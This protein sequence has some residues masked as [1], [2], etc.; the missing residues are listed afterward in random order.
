M[1]SRNKY[2]TLVVLNPRWSSATYL[3]S[4]SLDNKKDYT[5]LKGVLDEALEGYAKK[6]GPFEKKQQVLSNDGTHRFKHVTEFCCIKQKSGSVKEAFYALHHLKGFVWDAEKTKLP[7]SLQEWTK[8][9]GDITDAD[10]REDFHRIQVQLSRII[11]EDVNN[12]RGSLHNVRG[13]NKCFFILFIID[14]S[15]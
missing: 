7:S 10:L 9:A 3:D 12:H 11:I 1:L 2:C 4:G 8:C 13:S 14:L 6:G 5:K 15:T